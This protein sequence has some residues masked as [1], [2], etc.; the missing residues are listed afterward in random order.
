MTGVV[1]VQG[2]ELN[3]GDIGLI[4]G[5]LAVHRDWGGTRLSDALC[6]LWDWRNARG[7]IKDMAARTLCLKPERGGHIRLPERRRPSSNG[8]RNRH[9]PL[10]DYA[11]TLICGALRE[12]R[13]VA[14]SVVESGSQ[15]PR[16]F[17]CLLGRNY[18]LGHRN[19][20]GENMR[21]LVPRRATSAALP[22][23]GPV[24]SIRRT[25]RAAGTRATG[26]GR[27]L[28]GRAW[29]TRPG[30]TA[31]CAWRSRRSRSSR[32]CTR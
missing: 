3:A 17:N 21:Y 14:V 7:R 13:P 25:G 15:D 18:Y 9:A 29:R 2:R 32:W 1:V 8:F 27:T 20:V 24:R 11:T 6:C 31:R 12:L 4:Q 22:S 5:L 10:V 26:R 23:C 30:G 16:L 19:T 28:Q